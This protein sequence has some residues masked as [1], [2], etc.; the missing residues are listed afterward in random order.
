MSKL[1]RISAVALALSASVRSAS[2]QTIPNTGQQ[3]TPLAPSGSKFAPLNPGLADNPTWVAGQAVT[4]ISSPDHKTLLVLT[5]GYNRVNYTSGPKAGSRNPADSNEYVFV[6]DISNGAPVQ[7]QVIQVPNTYNGIVF[8]PSGTA[9]Y[10]TGGVDDNVHTY[11]LLG[12]IWSEDAGSPIA[13]GHSKGVGAGVPPAAAG[14]GITQDGAKLVVADYYNDAISVLTRSG[15]SWIKTAELD[16]RPGKINPAQSG[17][18]GGEYPF[19]VTVKGNTTAYVSS[20]RDREVVVVDIPGTPAVRSRIKVSG[21]PLKMTLNASQSTLYVAEEQTDSVAVINTVSNAVI[22]EVG[23]SAPPGLLG[24]RA[25]LHGNN[26]NSVTLSPDESMLYVTNGHTNNIAV[27]S[28]AALRTGHGV[29]GLI[30]TGWYPNSVTFSGDGKYVYVVNGKSPTKP[31]P[32]FCY[33]G[34]IPSLPAAGCN[35]SNEYNLQLIK[36]GLKSFPLPGPSELARLTQQVAD[37]NNYRSPE[38]SDANGTM[39][40]L[41]HHIQHVIYIVKENKTFDQ[42]LGDLGIGDGYAALTEFPF[43]I[44]PNQHSLAQNFVTLDHFYDA[45]EVSYDGWAWSTSARVTDI[46]ARQTPV[47]YAGRGLSYE[48]EGTNRGINV[49]YSSLADR[50]TSNPGTPNDPDVLPGTVN[51]AAP[52]GPGNQVNTGYLWDQAFRAGLSV[53]NYGFFFQNVGPSIINAN[54]PAKVVGY[55]ANAA[56]RPVTDPYFR[57]FDMNI[58]DFYLYKEWAREFDANYA[59]GGL[60]SLTLLRLPHDHTGSFRSALAGVNTPQLQVADNDYAVGLVVQKIANSIYKSNTLIFVIEDD[61]QNGGDHLESHRSIAF[62]VGPY[63][64][65]HAL[66]STPYNTVNMVRTIEDVLGL[67][68][69]NLN[70][71]TA[72]SMAD[73]FDIHEPDWSYTAT[74]SALLYNTQLPLPPKA[75]GLRIPKQRHDVNYWAKVTKGLDFSKEDLVDEDQYN[76]ILWKGIM[77]RKPYPWGSK[78]E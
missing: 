36:A 50:T 70:D 11:T 45:S 58:P 54:P 59:S 44:T 66:V 30:P 64:K 20:I 57:G 21:Q 12:G 37:N 49:S 22:A 62:I 38:Q 16:L 51:V 31:N 4:S 26:T 33:G 23:A 1:I 72:R 27:L 71:A 6:Y 17:T 43:G 34:V 19:W 61:S 42:I 68:P 32:G 5:S 24:S 8:D 35:A 74:P 7:K 73:V 56:L 53:R 65:Q 67:N 47:N 55:P 10:V 78:E 18:P 69:L 48:S 52:D 29:L 39:E 14:V 3:I 46:V 41:R 60:P 28:L 9:F 77:G 75:A 63:V 2:S 76:R 25:D 13:L 40:F 15:G